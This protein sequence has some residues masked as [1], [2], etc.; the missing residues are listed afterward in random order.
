MLPDPYLS[1]LMKLYGFSIAGVQTGGNGTGRWHDVRLQMRRDVVCELC[2]RSFS[3]GFQVGVDG[4]VSRGRRTMDVTMVT[5]R[6]ER[7]LRRRIRCPYCQ[8]VQRTA[9]RLFIRREVRHGVVGLITLGGTVLGAL[10]FA[11]GGYVLA[12]FIGLAIGLGL[13]VALV[14]T[15]TRWMLGQLFDAAPHAR[16]IDV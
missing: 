14:L 6:L 8:A 11:A 5:P 3:Y 2:G 4:A 9:R 10:T 15:L 13:A 7:E 1:D 12:G 16:D